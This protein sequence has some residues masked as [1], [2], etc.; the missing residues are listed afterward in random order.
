MRWIVGSSLRFRYV[1]VGLAAALIF[2]GIQQ[3]QK[4]KLDVFP[5]FAPTQVQIQTEA[6][7]LSASE[8]EQLITVPLENGL[9]GVPRVATVRS[10]SVP[11][12]SSIILLFKKGTSL[13]RA[14][15]LVQERLQTVAPTLPS[16]AS[17]PTM[18]PPV[19]TTSRVMAIGLTSR[20]LSQL[21]MSVSAFWNMRA[22]LLR[23][24]GVANVAIWGLRAKELQVLADP[25]RMAA[26]RVSL[27][28]LMGVTS[29]A[30]D[31]GV[32]PD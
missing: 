32:P 30:L 16:W 11:Q 1:V 26:A 13:V 10:E 15:Q 7:G 28:H 2:F 6:L 8:V 18:V 27:G 9:T 17:P 24:P 22:R 5:E 25:K 23:V 20:R 12:L 29:R 21:N 3:V 19:S 31:A 4:Q 14:R